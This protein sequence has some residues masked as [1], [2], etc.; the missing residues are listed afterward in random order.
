MIFSKDIFIRLPKITYRLYMALHLWDAG[1][2]LL[3]NRCA[4]PAHSI[5]HHLKRAPAQADPQPGL[6]GLLLHEGPDFIEFKNIAG[7]GWKQFFTQAWQTFGFFYP[8]GNRQA[9][10]TKDA[11]QTTDTGELQI[12]AQNLP[13]L[14]LTRA[15]CAKRRGYPK[16]ALGSPHISGKFPA[17]MAAHSPD[18]CQLAAITGASAAA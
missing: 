3:A 17:K 5:D 7:L 8:A 14:W 10:N 9:V 13:W 15:R 6:A 4:T 1:L 18:Y 11:L 2:E 16:L 12:S